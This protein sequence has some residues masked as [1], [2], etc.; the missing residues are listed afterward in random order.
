LLA[1][2]VYL[3]LGSAN[4]ALVVVVDY[5]LRLLTMAGGEAP[6]HGRNEKNLLLLSG[7][8]RNI[9]LTTFASI[10]ELGII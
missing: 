4:A 2:A 3:N 5:F 9:L 10:I 1:A 7:G 8:L 6:I